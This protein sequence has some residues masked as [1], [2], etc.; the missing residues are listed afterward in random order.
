LRWRIL[1]GQKLR[2][3]DF[4]DGIIMFDALVG[5]THLINASA[6]EALAIVES[7]PGI[8]TTEL[9]DRLLTSLDIADVALSLED[10]DELMW[11]LEFLNIV[12]VIGQ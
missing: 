8:S 3:E 11:R 2:F 10:V 1:P 4:D 5:A 7:C 12:C 6:A 9:R